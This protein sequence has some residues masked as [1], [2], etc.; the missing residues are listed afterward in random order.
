MLIISDGAR[1]RGHRGNRGTFDQGLE[2]GDTWRRDTL[3]ERIPQIDLPIYS[4]NGS[5]RGDTW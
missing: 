4:G 1:R 3:L 2:R 5:E